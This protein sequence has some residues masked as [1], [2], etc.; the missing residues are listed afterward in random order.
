MKTNTYECSSCGF[1]VRS[2]HQSNMCLVCGG[3]MQNI[4]IARAM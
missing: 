2:S 4:S 3:A 1:R